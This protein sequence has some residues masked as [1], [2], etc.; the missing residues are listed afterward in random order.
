MD[1]GFFGV[2][3]WTKSKRE[4]EKKNNNK[5]MKTTI[6]NINIESL[7]LGHWINS[8][9]LLKQRKEDIRNEQDIVNSFFSRGCSFR[10]FHPSIIR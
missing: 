10:F 4:R 7:F 2:K 9:N 1:E 6:I 5:E 8:I 3:P